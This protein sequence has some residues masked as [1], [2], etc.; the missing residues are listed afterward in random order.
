MLDR[1]EQTERLESIARELELSR[2]YRIVRRLHPLIT[3]LPMPAA[4]RTATL[5][6][7]DCETTGLDARR[8]KIIDLGVLVVE[9]NA[10]T[11]DLLRVLGNWTGLQDPGVP[12][13]PNITSL[14]GITD[15]MVAGQ[16]FDE[17]SL[18]DAME[19]IDLVIAHNASFDRPFLE[20][21]FPWFEQFPWACSFKLIDWQQEGFGS[22]K[23][24]FIAFRLGFF[25][26]G[27]RALVD[28]HALA[29]ALLMAKLPSTGE[30]ALCKVLDT[31][32][33]PDYV[34]NATGAPFEAKDL[35]KQRGYRWDGED[36][37]WRISV[38]ESALQEELDWLRASVYTHKPVRVQVEVRDS[39]VK[40]SARQGVLEWRSIGPQGDSGRA[41]GSSGRKVPF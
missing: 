32:E 12:I 39:L 36:R 13:A 24:E 41:F 26:D 2:D 4:R 16:S 3:P 7:L 5:A 22:S 18:R 33:A 6:F 25:Y 34:I 17:G 15:A 8:D 37:I 29:T 11:G 28:C 21:A 10:Q 9:I 40:Y 1:P 31:F 27:H 38:N 23:L 14:T 20:A 35:L 30:S 19:A